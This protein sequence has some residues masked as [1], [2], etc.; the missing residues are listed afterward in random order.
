MYYWV[1]YLPEKVTW[2]YYSPFVW[3]FP[4]KDPNGYYISK[5]S[6]KAP[7]LESGPLL[8]LFVIPWQLRMLLSL[9]LPKLQMDWDMREGKSP[10]GDDFAHCLNWGTLS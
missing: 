8:S 9:S 2:I 3:I 10:T 7:A 5:L 4:R 6:L 1:N